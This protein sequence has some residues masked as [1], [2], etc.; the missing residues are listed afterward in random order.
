MPKA[1]ELNALAALWVV[2]PYLPP[3]RPMN[4]LFC[5]DVPNSVFFSFVFRKTIGRGLMTR[6]A[7]G[8]GEAFFA[9]RS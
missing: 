7:A 4:V 1:V 8:G 6:Q 9:L 2:N 5:S 3:A